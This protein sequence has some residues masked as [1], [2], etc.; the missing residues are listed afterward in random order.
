MADP[1]G[2]AEQHGRVVFF[3]ILKGIPDHLIRL[4]RGTGIKD[5]KFG[6]LAE[7]ACI[8]L[9]L[10]GNGT[11]IIRHHHHHAALYSHIGQTHKGV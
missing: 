10:G 8:L 11:W 3:R 5:R 1:C 7:A 4:L 2:G 9:C 6:K